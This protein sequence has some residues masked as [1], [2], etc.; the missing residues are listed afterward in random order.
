MIVTITNINELS[1]I[2]WNISLYGSPGFAITNAPPIDTYIPM[3]EIAQIEVA[4]AST[5]EG[6]ADSSLVVIVMDGIPFVF[7]VSLSGTGV[8]YE[9]P[10]GE[11]IQEILDFI[12]KA[13]N[14]EGTLAGEGPGNS[15]AGRLGALI[16]M[17]EAAGDLINDGDYQQACQQ[18]QDAY[19]RCDGDFSPPD[20]VA[21]TARE[22]LAAK[23]QA[24]R[25][26]LGCDAM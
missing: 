20:F 17:I 13:V 15:A 3:G 18:L 11:Q 4:Y 21:G 5:A 24:L 9:P 8:A 1:A 23:I 6:Q 2:V 26:E 14:V 19:K 22:E 25:G 7:L 10:P 12:D 16:K